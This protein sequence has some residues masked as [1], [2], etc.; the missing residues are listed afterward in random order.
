M[1]NLY[2]AGM[3]CLLLTPLFANAQSHEQDPVQWVLMKT[4][5]GVSFYY[6][7]SACGNANSVIFKIENTT[8]NQKAIAVALP[9]NLS[10]QP[11]GS[12]NN[13]LLSVQPQGNLSGGCGEGSMAML[14]W[15]FKSTPE[16][17]A[18]LGAL[19]QLIN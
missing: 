1:K 11:A 10:N 14:S 6:A 9:G 19:F 4:E 18:E 2:L 8:Q 5:N 15:E 12:T 3:M 17:P 7:A 16:N 13:L